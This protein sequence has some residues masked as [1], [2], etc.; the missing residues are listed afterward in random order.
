MTVFK[1]EIE[2]KYAQT[3]K[4]SVQLQV[5]EDRRNHTTK[6]KRSGKVFVAKLRP[7]SDE[8]IALLEK[9]IAEQR[10]IDAACA[11]VIAEI[12]Q[13]AEAEKKAKRT[14]IYVAPRTGMSIPPQHHLTTTSA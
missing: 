13:E 4:V 1:G 14:I 8:I 10:K 6:R 11:S 5:F 3:L 2:T 12:L 9:A 7:N